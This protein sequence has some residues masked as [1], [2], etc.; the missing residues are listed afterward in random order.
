MQDDIRHKTPSRTR[1]VSG[2]GEAAPKSRDALYDKGRECE[3]GG[4][5]ICMHPSIITWVLYEPYWYYR[6]SSYESSQ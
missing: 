6:S 5:D 2:A 1:A 3:Y 4:I